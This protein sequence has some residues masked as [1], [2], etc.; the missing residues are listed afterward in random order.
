MEGRTDLRRVGAVT[1]AAGKVR[2][3]TKTFSTSV[4]TV[5]LRTGKPALAEGYAP[6]TINHCLSAV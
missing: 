6:R 1:A 2:R 5:N 3:R 4:G